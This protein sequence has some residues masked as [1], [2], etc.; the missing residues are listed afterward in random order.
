MQTVW[1]IKLDCFHEL[2]YSACSSKVILSFGEESYTTDSIINII[3]DYVISIWRRLG[4][5][6]GDF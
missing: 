2:R 3:Y 1:L 6:E 4:E 5:I